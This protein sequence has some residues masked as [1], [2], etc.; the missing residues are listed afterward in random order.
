[1]RRT[2]SLYVHY[3][4]AGKRKKEKNVGKRETKN[5]FILRSVPNVEQFFKNFPFEFALFLPFVLM[6]F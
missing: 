4:F 1:M 6:K 3:V 5:H 2:L